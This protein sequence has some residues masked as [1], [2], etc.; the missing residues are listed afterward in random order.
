MQELDSRR[1]VS[2]TL[3]SLS[4]FKE[5]IVCRSWTKRTGCRRLSCRQLLWT[6]KASLD[7][8]TSARTSKW[9]L[10]ANNWEWRQQIHKIRTKHLCQEQWWGQQTTTLNSK[11][12][13]I[14]C[15][16]LSTIIRQTNSGKV[17]YN[18]PYLLK[19]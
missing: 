12:H 10:R 18:A 19:N 7:V 6:W 4:T 9:A 5:D 3:L 14:C 16:S 15:I 13:N 8:P 2:A 17:L 11:R 1:L